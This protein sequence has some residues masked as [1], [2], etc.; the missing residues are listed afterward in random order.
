MSVLTCIECTLVECFGF[1][2]VSVGITHSP[3]S[4]E[5]LL[6]VFN[7]AGCVILSSIRLTCSSHSLSFAYSLHHIALYLMSMTMQT[8]PNASPMKCPSTPLSPPFPS[9]LSPLSSRT[10]LPPTNAPL[11]NASSPYRNAIC[12]QNSIVTRLSSSRCRNETL[13]S[14]KS[15]R[16]KPLLVVRSNE[17]PFGTDPPKTPSIPTCPSIVFRSCASLCSSSKARRFLPLCLFVQIVLPNL[18]SISL[19]LI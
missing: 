19:K 8:T 7:A 14:K 3:S 10:T 16:S 17:T 2:S 13:Y 5:T 18:N 15:S 11:P 6:T 12:L 1:H 9:P 4:L